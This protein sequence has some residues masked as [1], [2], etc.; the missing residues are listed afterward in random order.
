[1]KTPWR[2]KTREREREREASILNH[3]SDSKKQAENGKDGTHRMM[4]MM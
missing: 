3:T 2:R 4:I 1:M